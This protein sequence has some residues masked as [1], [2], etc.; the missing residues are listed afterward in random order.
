MAAPT[1]IGWVGVGVMGLSMCGHLLKAGY[2][3][4]V[5]TR[6]P[7]KADA[8]VA[9]GAA[10]CAT[11]AQVA[12]QSDVVFCM[13]GFPSDV[14][15]VILGDQGILSTLR[16]GGVVVDMTTSE[17]SLAVEVAA[18]CAAKGC[19]AMDAPVSGGDVGARN[20]TL[21]IMVGGEA[22]T[23]EMVRPLLLI[24]GKTITHCGAP[25]AGQHT[26]MVNQ[27]LIASTMVGV[28]EG[29]L[30]G[31]RAGLDLTTVI[32]AVGSGAAGSWSINTLGPRIVAR[33][34]DPGFYVEHFLKVRLSDSHLQ[35]FFFFVS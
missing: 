21:S 9:A 30:Y 16:P 11:P 13:V 8:L 4:A 19:H 22:A 1:K 27:I 31:H 24:M 35:F 10:L 14:R 5:S 20:A 7:A 2:S 15:S 29:L 34:F 18:A 6:T 32:Q 17:P 25:G 28:C 26:K 23:L 33:N 12:S 3:V